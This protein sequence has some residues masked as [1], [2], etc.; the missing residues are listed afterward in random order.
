MHDH[1]MTKVLVMLNTE[2]VTIPITTNSFHN[3]D[4]PRYL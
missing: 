2:G 3:T 4:G 1:A